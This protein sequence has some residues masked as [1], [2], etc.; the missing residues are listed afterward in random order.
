MKK[1]YL[2]S[3]YHHL[4]YLG[5]LCPCVF[6]LEFNENSASAKPFWNPCRS[7]RESLSS[8]ADTWNVRQ[9]CEKSLTKT[10]AV[11]SPTSF[12]LTPFLLVWRS[13][14]L[15]QNPYS[16]FSQEIPSLSSRWQPIP[17][18]QFGIHFPDCKFTQYILFCERPLLL[19]SPPQNEFL[20]NRIKYNYT[21]NLAAVFY[22]FLNHHDVS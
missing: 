10:L 13:H 5:S 4:I 8:T 6:G 2:E 17:E 1:N 22:V 19:F 7:T 15:L 12:P 3:W 9:G 14:D 21:L 16:I 18:D 20:T 11:H